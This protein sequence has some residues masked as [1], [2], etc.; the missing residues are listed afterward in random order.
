MNT[1]GRAR[2]EIPPSPVDKASR[3]PTPSPCYDPYCPSFHMMLAESLCE[4]CHTP[5]TKERCLHG[6]MH[7]EC[8]EY[9]QQ[10]D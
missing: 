10:D 8:C 1:P 4:A 5:M 7:V 9:P 6:D 3:G 2:R